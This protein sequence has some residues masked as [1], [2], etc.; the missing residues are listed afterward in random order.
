MRDILQDIVGERVFRPICETR[1]LSRA[2]PNQEQIE[3]E[4]ILAAPPSESREPDALR[5]L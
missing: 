1:S 2:R 3:S 4:S 5:T